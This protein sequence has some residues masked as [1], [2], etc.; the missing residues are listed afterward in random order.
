VDD[1]DKSSVAEEQYAQAR[2]EKFHRLAAKFNSGKAGDCGICGK[3][4]ERVVGVIF[5][6]ENI[7]A[8]ARCRDENKL[9]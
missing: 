4:F 7:F 5:D 9:G 3:Y 1:A 2:E 8:C 6:K